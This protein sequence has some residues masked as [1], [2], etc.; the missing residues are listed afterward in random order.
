MARS[1]QENRNSVNTDNANEHCFKQTP[2][3]CVNCDICK[4]GEPPPQDSLQETH[5]VFNLLGAATQELGPSMVYYGGGMGAQGVDIRF[6]MSLQQQVALVDYVRGSGTVN[7]YGPR[8]LLNTAWNVRLMD[9]LATFT[10]D[11]EVVQFL[12]FGWPLNHDGSETVCS[13]FNH[14]SAV[15]YSSQVTEYI[16]TEIGFGCLLGPFLTSPWREHVAC[17]PLSTRPKKDS[18][19]RHIIMD[20]S[21][22]KWGWSVNSG[23]DKDKYLEQIVHLTYPTVDRLCRRA[24]ELGPGWS[25]GWKKDMDRAFKQII[26]CPSSWPLLG[27]MWEGLLH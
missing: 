18:S 25:F 5:A 13:Y 19:K 4:I 1:S 26:M 8:V 27:I 2:Q 7:V 6:G 21:W 10:S 16:C 23:I 22:L 12:C 14:P 11:R 15:R 3:N 17:S 9:A 24:A 20:L